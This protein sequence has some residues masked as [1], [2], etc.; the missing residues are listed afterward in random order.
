M[1]L[2]LTWTQQHPILCLLDEVEG[3]DTFRLLYFNTCILK[4]CLGL[5][6]GGEIGPSLSLCSFLPWR[7]EFDNFLPVA[8]AKQCFSSAFLLA[9]HFGQSLR[10][11]RKEN[12]TVLA[13]KGF[14][15]VFLARRLCKQTRNLHFPAL[16][17]CAV[18]RTW[19]HSAFLSKTL[20][21]VLSRKSNS[22]QR[23]GQACLGKCVQI[24]GH[25]VS[26]LSFRFCW[27]DGS[28]ML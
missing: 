8:M 6:C 18:I 1:V 16:L 17:V 7:L 12:I 19:S 25:S 22:V 11:R 10:D 3:V 9:F 24:V 21:Y 5:R 14:I 15:S 28:S 23:R 13:G 20:V 27:P 4:R 2:L 26:C